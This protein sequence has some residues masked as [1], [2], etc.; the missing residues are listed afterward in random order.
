MY[1]DQRELLLESEK[2]QQHTDFPATWI[3]EK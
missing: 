2:K 1:E 3:R